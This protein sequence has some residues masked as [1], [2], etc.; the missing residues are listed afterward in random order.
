MYGLSVPPEAAGALREKNL[1]LCDV[2]GGV[3]PP[4]VLTAAEKAMPPRV[5]IPLSMDFAVVDIGFV[6][7]ADAFV[8]VVTGG[9]GAEA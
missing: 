1:P 8:I 3:S 2:A 6:G 4:S 9:G 7:V 5:F